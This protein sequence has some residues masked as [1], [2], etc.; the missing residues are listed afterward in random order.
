MGATASVPTP[1]PA[2]TNV[3]IESPWPLS[4]QWLTMA[5]N[6]LPS[7]LDDPT[8]TILLIKSALR[9]AD[10]HHLN[11]VKIDELFDNVLHSALESA[12]CAYVANEHH[13]VLR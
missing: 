4:I 8:L 10:R 11:G 3:G 5:L 12:L 1:D 7:L 2:P 6:Y 9:P 13:K